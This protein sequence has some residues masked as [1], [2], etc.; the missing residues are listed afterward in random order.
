MRKLR[1]VFAGAVVLLVVLWLIAEPTIFRSTTF[2]GLRTTM[3]QLTGVVAMGCMG[4]AM[5]LALRPMWPQAWL[6][7]LLPA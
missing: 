7:V 1:H 5:V 3:L 2:F 4:F 6:G